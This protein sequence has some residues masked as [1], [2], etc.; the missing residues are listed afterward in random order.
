[1]QSLVMR[2]YTTLNLPY[3]AMTC[4]T[5]FI[6][7]F[8]DTR[9]RL[10]SLDCLLQEGAG[11]LANGGKWCY[12]TYPMPHGALIPSRMRQARACHDFADARKELWLGTQSARWTATLDTGVRPLWHHGNV[13]S[14]LGSAKVLLY[15]HR[16]PDLLHVNLLREPVPYELLIAA[17]QSGL[18]AEHARILRKHV[19]KGGLLLTSGSTAHCPGMADLLGIKVVQ[20]NALGEGC[21]L[22]A[23]GTSVGILANWDKVEPAGAEVWWKLYKPW[24]Q[25]DRPK[26]MSPNYPIDGMMDEEQPQ[27][28]GMPAVTA[29]RLGSG[30]AVHLAADPF[31]EYWKSG[32][33]TSWAFLRELL[34]RMQPE[35]WFSCTAPTCVEVS[36]RVRGDELLIHLVNINPGRDMA[37]TG[38]TDLHV[39]DIPALAPFEIQVRCLREPK[40]VLLEPGRAK[41]DCRWKEGRLH[42]SIPSLAIH[43]CVWIRPWRP[44]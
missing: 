15:A 44:A 35:P 23:D 7:G 27:E 6:H 43:S 34:R 11:V 30:L 17:N 20:P 5:Q 28:A 29:R 21:L 38:V 39:Y 14:L 24:G 33:F 1:M 10:K 40:T 12:W 13:G 25:D 32:H 41:V 19:E 31:A 36:L 42:C 4:D 3:D 8:Y 26:W 16:S 37:Q 2:H 22:L 9:S 18:T